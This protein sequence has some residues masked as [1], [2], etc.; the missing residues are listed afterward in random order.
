MSYDYSISMYICYFVHTY[1]NIGAY[2]QT[3]V[4]MF[5]C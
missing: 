2:I 1:I 5:Y 4:Y 3:W